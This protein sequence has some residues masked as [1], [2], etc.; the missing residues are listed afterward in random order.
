MTPEA[1]LPAAAALLTA[2]LVV[3]GAGIT[4]IGSLGLLRLRSFFERVH[5]P[6]L[7]TTL[8]TA[9]ILLGSMI[10]FSALQTRPVTHEILIAVFVTVTTPVTLM[11]LVR[12]TSFRYRAASDLRNSQQPASPGDSGANSSKAGRRL[13]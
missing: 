5:A 13:S 1:D 11:L 6:T 8:G 9:C 3:F 4:F 10:F 7:G 12:A 2:L